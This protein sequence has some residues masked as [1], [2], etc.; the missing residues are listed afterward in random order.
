MKKILGLL[1]ACM[2]VFSSCQQDVILEEAGRDVQTRSVSNDNVFEFTDG[3]IVWN[4][5]KYMLDYAI[6]AIDNPPL[7]APITIPYTVYTNTGFRATDTFVISAGSRYFCEENSTLGEWL[8]N[9]M[10]L[11][12]IYS[13]VTDVVVGKYQ[14]SGKMKIVGLDHLDV[15]PPGVFD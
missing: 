5:E 3:Y 10:G 4:E 13:H 8:I 7:D 9:W 1:F 12:P 2:A 6:V 14:Y 11:N 15:I